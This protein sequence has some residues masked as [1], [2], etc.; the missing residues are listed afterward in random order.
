MSSLTVIAKK[1]SEREIDI[2]SRAVN[3]F[4]DLHQDNNSDINQDNDHNDYDDHNCYC[5]CY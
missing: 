5:Y 4:P 2:I 3:L 1:A